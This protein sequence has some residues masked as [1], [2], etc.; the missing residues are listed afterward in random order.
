M[1]TN[2]LM[3]NYSLS[4]I[5]D[6]ITK[7]KKNAPMSKRVSKR[8]IYN[9][10]PLGGIN[11]SII[12]LFF[13]TLPF[14]EFAAIFN[15]YIY[16]SIGIAQSIVFYIIFMSLIMVAI[17]GIVTMNNKKVINNIKDSWEKYF[18]NV[19]L[20]LVLTTRLSPYNDF[21]EAYAQI[22]ESSPNDEELAQG[23]IQAFATM[24]EENR[25]LLESI[26]KDQAS[27]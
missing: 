24:Q 22:K 10:G 12:I 6:T 7:Y 18:P 4:T 14:V 19:D 27:N 9:Q 25:D 5:L 17:F 20:D 3:N 11:S 23:L 13:M 2:K 21:Y 16:G 1:E 26:R 8:T 15:P